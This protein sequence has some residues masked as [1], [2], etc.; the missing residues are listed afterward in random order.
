MRCAVQR[1]LHQPASRRWQH[2]Y[3]CVLLLLLFPALSSIAEPGAPYGEQLLRSGQQWAD[4]HLPGEGVA[5]EPEVGAGVEAAYK[6]Y[7]EQLEVLQRRGGPY[8]V[9]L[10][11]TLGAMAALQRQRGDLQGAESL[12][13]RA[14]H[15]QRINEG[16][17]SEGQLE[18]LRRLI[19]L[20]RDGQDLGALDD[21]YAY[22]YFLQG[23]AQPPRNRQALA[24]QLEYLRWQREAL[25]LGVGAGRGQRRLLELLELN[26][27][28]L[29]GTAAG[30]PAALPPASR[31]P[32]FESQLRNLYLLQ[33]SLPPVLDDPGMRVARRFDL[34]ADNELANERQRLEQQRR[35]GLARGRKL[36]QDAI[37][38]MPVD[39]PERRAARLALADWYQWHGQTR[40]ATEIYSALVRELVAANDTATLAAWFAEPLEL[41]DNGAFWQPLAPGEV[42]SAP[43]SLG[44]KVDE[45]GRVRELASLAVPEA[46]EEVE[47]RL[48]RVLA[49]TRFRPRFDRAGVPRAS[50]LERSYEWL[51]LRRSRW[52]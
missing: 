33:D 31:W 13:A 28:L 2:L 1:N 48:R 25:R 18:L 38:S 12:Y 39:A 21:R 44:F 9:G 47:T 34:Q 32:L 37:T 29:E 23:G 51:P 19:E 24:V 35:S 45:R 17:R 30:T 27:R 52:P 4:A 36:L 50:Q 14:L 40:R 46:A 5:A 26:D 3:C 49:D 42:A 6:G 11:E 15:I 10:S 22:L 7:L 20:A 8:A 43:I 41:P 16:L